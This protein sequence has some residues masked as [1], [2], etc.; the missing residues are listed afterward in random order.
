MKLATSVIVSLCFLKVWLHPP[1]VSAIVL[2]TLLVSVMVYAG[3]K[4]GNWH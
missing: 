1:A 3:F 4:T 2:A